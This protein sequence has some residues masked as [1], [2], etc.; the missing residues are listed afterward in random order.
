MSIY[1]THPDL[2]KAL[3]KRLLPRGACRDC[4]YRA[5]T[6]A[7]M[8][9]FWARNRCPNCSCTHRQL[10]D[11]RSQAMTATANTFVIKVRDRYLVDIVDRGCVSHIVVG[12]KSNAKHFDSIADAND[13][14]QQHTGLLIYGYSTIEPLS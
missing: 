7:R 14:R 5:R 3:L 8:A 10:W 6:A 2:P 1:G 9:F 11:A 12:S 4:V 13:Y